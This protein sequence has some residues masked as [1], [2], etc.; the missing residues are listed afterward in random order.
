MQILK[1][2]KKKKKKKLKI[3]NFKDKNLSQPIN[4]IIFYFYFFGKVGFE[5]LI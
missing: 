5:S 2:K 1:K 3:Q 4:S